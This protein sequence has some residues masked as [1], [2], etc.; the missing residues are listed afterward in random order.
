MVMRFIVSQ[1]SVLIRRSSNGE[2]SAVFRLQ[3]N[4]FTKHFE[5]FISGCIEKMDEISTEDEDKYLQKLS[6]YLPGHCTVE[7]FTNST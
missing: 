6:K 3:T 4:Q 2:N 5:K 1:I 7:N